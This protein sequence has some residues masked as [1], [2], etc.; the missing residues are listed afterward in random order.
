MKKIILLK[1]LIC[2]SGLAIFSQ[3]KNFTI[4]GKVKDDKSELLVG[5][6]VRVKNSKGGTLTDEQ[7]KFRISVSSLPA[8]LVFSSAEFESQETIVSNT[9]ELSVSLRPSEKLL[10]VVVV[11]GDRSERKLINSAVSIE[12]IG[13]TDFANAP[14]D[15]YG[16]ILM[17]KSLD[18]TL[19]SMT[20]KTYS[21]RGFNGSGSSRVTQLM[22]GMDNQAPG[23]NF[24]LGNFIGLTDPDIE[25]IEILPGAS[26]A[27][28]G[29]GGVNGTILLNSKN[30]FKYTGLS[31]QV[32]NGITD[33]SKKQRNKIGGYYDYS[34]RWA[35]N[36]NNRFAFK[37]G[38]Q[39]IQANDWLAND[40]SNY[41]RM[42]S[43]GKVIAGTRK[44][45]PNYD[46]VNVYGDET[47]VD[48]RQFVGAIAG[49]YPPGSP[50][51]DAI[52][53]L[54]NS[55]TN[56]TP[57]S[58]TGYNEIDIIDPKT[59]NI[60]LSGSLHY[61]FNNKIEAIL[62][63]HWGTGNTVYTGNNR[64]AFKNIKVGQYKLELK[65]KNWFL[66]GY[67]TQENAGDAYSATVTSQYFNE[68]WKPSYNP[69][70][71][72]GSW[73][74]Q[75]AQAYIQSRFG[76]GSDIISHNMAR[77]FADQ[78]RPTQGSAQFKHL[79][80]S[81][82]TVPL[83]KGGLF[84]D[85]SQL[86]MTEGQY[87]FKDNIKFAELIIGGNLKKYILSSQGTIF[88]DTAGAL[89]INEWGGYAQLTK[90]LFDEK[91]V[92]S[93]AGR[94]D[95]NEN[96]KGKFTPRVTALVK[97][98]E[99]HNLRLSYQTAYKFPTTL[100]QWIKLDVGNVF[101]LG[102]LPWINDYM[103][104]KTTPTYVYN[105]VN[106]PVPYVY[107]E[108]KPESMRSF[109]VGYKSIINKKLLLD[110]YAYFGKYTDFLGRI[111]LVQPTTT[112][113]PFSIVSNSK[114]DIKTWGAGVG[115]DYK[116][117]KNYFT[118]IN[119]YTDN[120][121]NV[122]SGFMAG[123]NTPKYRVNAGFGNSGMGKKERIG[124]NIN[125]RWQDS[126]FWE[127]GGFADGNVRTYTTLDAQVNYKLPKIKS[128][129]KLGGTNITNKYYQTSF[130]NPYISG[131]YYLSY[132][133]NIL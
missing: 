33:I 29:P 44:T 20:Y 109:E 116:M 37:I 101:L 2:I 27:L 66:R 78:G 38:A 56:P 16:Q 54:Y 76:G 23:L 129:V 42:G 121:T 58:R 60:K 43:G 19:S 125:L 110:M 32:K 30:P 50:E 108:L 120:L 107:K 92:L 89:K 80:D 96:F 49:F 106:P 131:M 84:L 26:S 3:E 62:A 34:L 79:F 1:L 115:I 132:T 103:Y 97:L 99:G 9:D 52:L 122:P 22:D 51:R 83:P 112:N 124:Y 8:T 18:V 41:L 113:K 12:K 72:M 64:Y 74:L 127:G 14:T 65:H 15:P 123:Y 87:N 77:G 61:N 17:K 133:Y 4:T 69:A 100:Q 25:S 45:D 53:Q 128:M 6:F 104:V 24:S 73:Y 5:V 21:T 71:P 111:V 36:F 57:V 130:G 86:W 11:A 40:T 95:K 28:Y 48:V 35:K 98:A 68:A 119:A 102:G 67:T 93:A 55:M 81:V 75:Y 10:N 59:K 94:F 118:F 91:L 105:G 39:F 126:F 85:N 63:G 114:T 117:A 90:K 82:R 47:S 31:I 70:N 13:K 46:G 88:I 7:G